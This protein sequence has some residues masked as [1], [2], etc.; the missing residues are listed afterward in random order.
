MDHFVRILVS[1]V[2]GK[3]GHLLGKHGKYISLLNAMVRIEI[4]KIVQRIA[5][6]NLLLYTY[7]RETP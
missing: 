4:Y 7:D 5:A 6:E 3:A 2:V 1:F